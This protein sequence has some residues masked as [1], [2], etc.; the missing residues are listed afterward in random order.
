MRGRINGIKEGE[1]ERME[2]RVNWTK[3]LVKIGGKEGKVGM[4]HLAGG[5]RGVKELERMEGGKDGDN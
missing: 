4:E 1:S 5:I 3:G 2:G